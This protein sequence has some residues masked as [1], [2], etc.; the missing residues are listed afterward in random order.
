MSFAAVEMT[1]VAAPA[2]PINRNHNRVR[3]W[4]NAG[5]TS[6]GNST[7]TLR[8]HEECPGDRWA[9]ALRRR[10][11]G[12]RPGTLD[13][14]ACAIAFGVSARTAEGWGGGQAP[15]LKHLVRAWRLFGWGVVAEVL[16]DDAADA[17]LAL[18]RELAELEGRLKLLRHNLGQVGT[19]T[20]R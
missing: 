8:N 13:T 12:Q 14:K 10:F 15:N 7:V 20:R 19:R 9:A 16:G 1:G 3:A 5:G 17:S 18:D 6:M 2:D 11:P 4:N